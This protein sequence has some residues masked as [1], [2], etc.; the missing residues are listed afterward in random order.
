MACYHPLP[1]YYRIDDESGKKRLVFVDDNTLP[2]YEKDGYVY[3]GKLEIPCGQC[4]G[5]RL[6]YSRQWAV[7][8]LLEAMKWE[9]NY[10]LTLTYDDDHLPES[11][12][13]VIDDDTGE[14]L[15]CFDTNP[16]V[17]EH[18]RSFIKNLRRQLK[19]HYNHQGLRV[20]YCGEYGSISGRPHYHLILFNIPELPLTFWKRN[21]EGSP[22]YNCDFIDKIWKKGYSVIAEVN[23]NTC[24]Y[25]ARYMIKK[26]KG[27]DF[28]YYEQNGLVPEF[29]GCSRRPGIARTFYDERKQ[30]VYKT[31]EIFVVGSR[32]KVQSLRPPRYFDRLYDIDNPSDFKI[33]KKKRMRSSLEALKRLKET[34]SLSKKQYL[35]LKE[36]NK[37][38]SIKKLTRNL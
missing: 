37:L 16:L 29:S 32:G 4:I 21:H 20:Y 30:L 6:E 24:A 5:C 11:L 17:P 1:A 27:K 23:W 28:S 8:C 19:Y 3:H 22:M 36:G 2:A 15:E 10:F 7:R 31:D 18:C 34:T 33:I 25:V 13:S 14:V 35:A 38:S 26:H 12:P 9:N